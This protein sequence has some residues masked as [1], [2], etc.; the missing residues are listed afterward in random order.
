[1]NLN[2]VIIFFISVSVI[3]GGIGLFCLR[4]LKKSSSLDKIAYRI[5]LSIP[6]I[7]LLVT[8]A[9]A[10][11]AQEQIKSKDEDKG[12]KE[13]L[14]ELIIIPIRSVEELYPAFNLSD[15]DESVMLDLINILIDNGEITAAALEE[16]TI[17]FH[18][19]LEQRA[20]SSSGFPIP[21][22]LELPE[23]EISS[24]LSDVQ[25]VEDCLTQMRWL[26]EKLKPL[27]SYKQQAPFAQQELAKLSHYL[28][29]RAKDALYWGYKDS[30]NVISDEMTWLFDEFAFVG[31]INEYIYQDHNPA[32][33][34]DIYYRLSQ[35]FDYLNYIADTEELKLN[36]NFIALICTTCAFEES[37][38][39]GF[40]PDKSLYSKSLWGF[41]LDILYRVSLDVDNADQEGFFKLMNEVEN[42][43]QNAALSAAEV[44]IIKLKLEKYE[45]YAMW[46]DQNVD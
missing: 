6:L 28:A 32:M 15:V 20:H 45:L 37:Q 29:I 42:S 14:P 34:L 18:R 31:I 4:K 22:Y 35:L 12:D 43:L 30:S 23:G 17:K 44:K 36:M 8:F 25:T 39:E 11:V 27:L 21:S 38:K 3:A 26:V 1:M 33:L 5:Y 9:T 41:H 7:L 10:Y 46:R 40:E 2:F 13:S 19:F 24:V 16:G